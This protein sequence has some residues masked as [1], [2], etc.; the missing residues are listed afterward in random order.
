MVC[1]RVPFA[2]QSTRFFLERPKM[3]KELL[4][5]FFIVRSKNGRF[6]VISSEFEVY[7]KF[8]LLFNN[9]W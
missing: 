9:F 2:S 1:F 5:Y 6:P 7:E 4:L 8:K 3:Y